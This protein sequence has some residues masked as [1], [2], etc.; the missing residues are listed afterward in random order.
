MLCKQLIIILPFELV[1][2]VP[3]VIGLIVVE[4]IGDQRCQVAV[5]A[6]HVAGRGHDGTHVFVTVLDTLLHLNMGK[7]TVLT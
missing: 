7:Y 1:F 2:F 6:V 4:E 3:D 5:D